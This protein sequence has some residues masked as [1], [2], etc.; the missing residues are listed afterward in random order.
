MSE[1]PRLEFRCSHELD[2]EIFRLLSKRE[3]QE[4]EI[5][6]STLLKKSVLLGL[7]I[8]KANPSLIHNITEQDFCKGDNSE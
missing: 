8:L 6:K 1:Y 2:A 5:T 3:F 7:Q 4:E